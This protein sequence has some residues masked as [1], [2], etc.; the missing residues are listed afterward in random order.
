MG[1]C[2]PAGRL[3]VSRVTVYRDLSEHAQPEAAELRPLLNADQ[4]APQPIWHRSMKI[5]VDARPFAS[6]RMC[7][8]LRTAI[9]TTAPRSTNI[10]DVSS[11]LLRQR[12]LMPWASGDFRSIRVPTRRV[13]E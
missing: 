3:D 10:S 5:A 2:H 9:L 11:S 13:R 1:T 8:R 7:H 6:A 12:Y 4:A